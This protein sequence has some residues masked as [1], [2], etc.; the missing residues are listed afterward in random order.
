MFSRHY[1]FIESLPFSKIDKMVIN[2]LSSCNLIDE[3]FQY[4]NFKNM[5]SYSFISRLTVV[6]RAAKESRI[7]ACAIKKCDYREDIY[8]L[9]RCVTGVQ[10]HNQMSQ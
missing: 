2:H 9:H 10:L 6:S 5:Y 7:Y 8:V 3:K 4:N 1:P